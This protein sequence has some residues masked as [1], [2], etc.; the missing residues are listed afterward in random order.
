MGSQTKLWEKKGTA[1]AL[2][3]CRVAIR[4]KVRGFI[5][6]PER[7]VPHIGETVDISPYRSRYGGHWKV[8]DRCGHNG[9]LKIV[10]IRI[11]DLPK[12]CRGARLKKEEAAQAV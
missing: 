7:K 6:L 10:L 2:A 9:N 5:L 8:V 1:M 3:K 12:G 11:S 4:G